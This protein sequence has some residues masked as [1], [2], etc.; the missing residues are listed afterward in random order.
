MGR[1][2]CVLLLPTLTAAQNLI[3]LETPPL[4]E[5]KAFSISADG[6][7]V[8]GQLLTPDHERV[9][10]YWVNTTGRFF[11]ELGRRQSTARWIS[12]NGNTI[13]GWLR[14]EHGYPAAFRLT[15]T[16]AELLGALGPDGSAATASSADGSVVVGWTSVP[17]SARH[18]FRW[19]QETGMVDLGAL[20]GAG[21]LAAAV[22]AD[23]RVVVGQ[24]HSEIGEW[25]AFR[26]VDG[27]M[28]NLGTLGGTWAEAFGVSAD[29]SVVVGWAEHPTG[30]MSAFRWKDGEG[31]RDL[32]TLGGAQSK[33]LAVS[34]DGSL[35]V[36]WSDTPEGTRRAFRWAESTGMEDLTEVY[37]A[38]LP[39]GSE[40]REARAITPDGRFI[41]GWGYR[42]ATGRLEAYLLDT[43]RTGSSVQGSPCSEA[44]L[45]IE[46]QPV[47]GNGMVRY[48]VPEA[49]VVRLELYD[50]L[51]CHRAV[52]FEGWQPAG[53]HTQPLP[54]LRA[55]LYLCR[56]QLG[57]RI[58]TAP[59]IAL[60]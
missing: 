15:P 55:G 39:D 59:I 38:L 4:W 12:A 24:A 9:A 49:A 43:Q 32:G 16:S 18:A 23:G 6:H 28:Q 17:G 1:N 34:A 2:L 31:I 13:V 5:S 8:V 57:Q 29:G 54:A 42:K 45:S 27:T 25:R 7:I 60:R 22:S 37:R 30:A 21:S 40:L 26:W 44:A 46:P 52:L 58:L 51:G 35:V 14:D 48:T 56:L 33:A 19:T 10:Y 50:A 47:E 20:G 36:G 11:P 53:E 3:W 41:V